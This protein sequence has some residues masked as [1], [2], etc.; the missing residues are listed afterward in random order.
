MCDNIRLNLESSHDSQV[1]I[2]KR[3]YYCHQHS[4]HE[5]IVSCRRKG[6]GEKSQNKNDDAMNDDDDDVDGP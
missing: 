5:A 1:I 6:I 2:V 3:Y 4:T